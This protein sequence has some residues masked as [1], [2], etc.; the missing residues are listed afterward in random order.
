MILVD[1]TDYVMICVNRS[2]AT[3][4][5]KIKHEY[6]CSLLSATDMKKNPIYSSKLHT[7]HYSLKIF[8]YQIKFHPLYK[9]KNV[10]FF[11]EQRTSS[12]IFN[13]NFIFSTAI[14]C[15]HAPS[16]HLINFVEIVWSH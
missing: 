6:Q 13:K 12:L 14:E 10:N 4:H 9:K 16:S 15:I 5:Y 8:L 7:V 11:N 1:T 2:Y 3:L